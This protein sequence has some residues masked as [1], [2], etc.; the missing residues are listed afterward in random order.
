MDDLDVN[1]LDSWERVMALCKANPAEARRRWRRTRQAMFLRPP[2]A[3]C[4]AIRASDRRIVPEWNVLMRDPQ[5]VKYREAHTLVMDGKLIGELTAPVTIAWPG[6]PLSKAARKLGK[7]AEALRHWLPVKRPGRT[8]AERAARQPVRWETVRKAGS[9]LTVRYTAASPLGHFGYDV[10]VV[11]SE[12]PLDPNARR[13]DPPHPMWG[14]LWQ[15]LHKQLIPTNELKVRRVPRWRPRRG[16]MEFKGWE[17]A[18]PGRINPANPKKRVRCGRRSMVLYMPMPI[19]TVARALG[20]GDGL[21]MGDAEAQTESTG[22]RIAGRWHPGWHD[23]REDHPCFACERCWNVRQLS[24]TCYRGWNDFVTY[25]SGGL[26]Y[27]R[28]VVRPEWVKEVRK[29]AY[30]PHV[31]RKRKADTNVDAVAAERADA[32]VSA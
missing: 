14:T 16:V 13:G 15:S 20:E 5:A 1:L 21:E 17:W 25:I 23:P 8:R 28:E 18:C 27:G 4:L 29:Q 32:A 30:R 7:H 22:L 31:R 2:R 3:W 11:W 6:E 12:G 9:P 19:Y 10:P 24:L 26:L